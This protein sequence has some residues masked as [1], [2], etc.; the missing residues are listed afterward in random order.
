MKKIVLVGF[1]AL[2]CLAVQAQPQRGLKDGYDVSAF[3]TIT[4]CWNTPN[5]DLMGS[6]HF[7]L[8]E[9]GKP[10][11]FTVQSI[12]ADSNNHFKKS[13]LLLWEDMASHSQQ[14]D[15]TRKL[16][17]GFFS[18]S[19]LSANDRFNVAVFNRQHDSRPHVLTTLSGNFTTD[20]GNLADAV[21][22][23]NKS[24][25][26]FSTFPQQS[27]LYLAINE[28]IEMLKKEPADRS[29]V[30]VVVTA[31]LNVKA[32]GAST[33]METVRQN[34]IRAGI[35]IYVVK[36]PLAGNAPE[37]NTLAESTY[38]LV[39]SSVDPDVAVMGLTDFYR[40]FGSR[41]KGQDYKF[42]FT[43]ETVRDGKPHPLR[44]KVDMVDFPI[45]PY[46][47]PD[48]TFGMWIKNHVL[49]VIIL[50]VVLAGLVVM[51]V[52]FVRNSQKKRQRHEEEMRMKIEQQHRENEQRNRDALNAMRR[53][54]DAKEQAVKL[55]RE[56]QDRIAA[57]ERLLKLMQTKNLFPRLQCSAG[58]KSFS[59]NIRKTVVTIG[60]DSSTDVAF[61]A[62]ND[63]FD[64]M[65][66][67]GRHA[68][69]VFNGSAFEVVNVSR[70]YTQGI[71]VN[72]QFFQRCTLR[73][74]DMIGLG[75]ALITFYI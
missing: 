3:P 33:E 13:I 1:F 14:S 69:I 64:N 65:T 22:R 24:G 70:S 31:G 66:V 43:T 42:T 38:G 67:S 54:Q 50:L 17:A 71:V 28:G 23:F 41:L 55:E 26:C 46:K 57:E 18:Q 12:P 6:E 7:A 20:V 27:D 21:A 8:T 39:F 58:D 10:L 9:N 19:E 32:A 47:A 25:E 73:N 60:R 37:V 68:E 63:S 61:T 52:L 4:F 48:Q 45:P 72:G 29:G 51:T 36:Y 49:L 34:A 16:L 59:Y 56:K 44:L 5:P 40:Q 53:E 35:P 2:L 75:E 11:K 30:L 62:G 74:G 15:F